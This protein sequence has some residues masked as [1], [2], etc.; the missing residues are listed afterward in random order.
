MCGLLC[1]ALYY[2]AYQGENQNLGYN[3]AQ[4]ENFGL[5]CLIIVFVY[6]LC[7]LVVDSRHRS[8]R[9][10]EPPPAAPLCSVRPGRRC[11]KNNSTGNSFSDRQH[12]IQSGVNQSVIIL[13]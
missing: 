1:S 4:P 3:R 7:K 13:V 5:G 11:G 2:I 10:A 8:V 12:R 9:Y 6:E